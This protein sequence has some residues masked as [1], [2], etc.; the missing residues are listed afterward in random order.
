MLCKLGR[1]L[2]NFTNY[3]N[4]Y[5]GYLKNPENQVIASISTVS[6]DIFSYEALIPLQRGVKVVIANE[7]EQTTPKLLNELMIK[8]KVTITQSTPSVMQIFVNNI[9]SIPA[10]RNLRYLTLTGE[11]VPLNLVNRLKDLC[12]VTIY[13]GYG[14]TETYYCT[15]S[16]VKGDFITI[17]KPSYNDQMYILDN[18]L[19]P[20][21]VG[22]IGEIYISG[23]GVARRIFK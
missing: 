15:L 8:N 20:V 2:V 11:Q 16:E 7:D 3:C 1:T 21:P 22:A 13:D 19:K 4:D 10:L 5:V 12:N 9:D 14:P 6:F 23:Y 17:G 18:N